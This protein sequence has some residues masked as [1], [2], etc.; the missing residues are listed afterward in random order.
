MTEIS[1]KTII[2]R[3]SGIISNKLD[4]EIIMMSIEKGEYYGLNQI[5]SRIWE[6]IENPISFDILI[7]H[8]T[9]EFEV[10][11]EACIADVKTFLHL[12]EEKNLVIFTFPEE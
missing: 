1:S 7:T 5:A 8:L 4:D 12:L 3:N 10:S 9:E 11:R 2:N 6:I